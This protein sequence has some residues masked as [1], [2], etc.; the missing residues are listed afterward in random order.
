M[1]M[2]CERFFVCN[3]EREREREREAGGRERERCVGRVFFNT[4]QTIPRFLTFAPC[5]TFCR[6]LATSS[7]K[8]FS[9][10]AKSFRM[11]QLE[12]A[13]L[14]IIINFILLT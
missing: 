10:P 13:T 9:D 5:L 4:L 3:P 6:S 7:S 8:S 12:T 11:S 14:K 2:T 1:P